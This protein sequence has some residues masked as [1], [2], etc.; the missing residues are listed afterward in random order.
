MTK[1]VMARAARAMATATKTVGERQQQ[2]QYGNKTGDC[3]SNEVA[4][5]KE[6]NGQGGK[7]NSND[8]ENGG[9]QRGQWQGQ[10][11]Q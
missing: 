5:N 2:W 8:H 1:R 6:G 3:E 7:G 10:K 9:Q 4:G 11:G